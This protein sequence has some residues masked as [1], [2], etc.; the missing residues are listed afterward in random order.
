MADYHLWD[1]FIPEYSPNVNDFEIIF[2]P[3]G[4]AEGSITFSSEIGNLF[5]AQPLSTASG[6]IDFSSSPIITVNP[7]PI[8]AEGGISI[9]SDMGFLTETPP[10]ILGQAEGNITFSSEIPNLRKLTPISADGNIAIEST[11][12]VLIPTTPVAANFGLK[13]KSSKIIV[14][15]EEFGKK[16]FSLENYISIQSQLGSLVKTQPLSLCVGEITIN[17]EMGQLLPTV[18]LGNASFSILFTS[19]IQKPVAEPAIPIGM[20]SRLREITVGWG[21]SKSIAHEITIANA[22]PHDVEH[23]IQIAYDTTQS[24]N[25]TSQLKWGENSA[26]QRS[27]AIKFDQPENIL[28]INTIPWGFPIIKN[29]ACDV[30]W[31]PQTTQKIQQNIAIHWNKISPKSRI[32]SIPFGE[33]TPVAV[34]YVIPWGDFTIEDHKSQA[35]TIPWLRHTSGQNYEW[36]ILS[37]KQLPIKDDPD[38]PPT[39]PTYPIMSDIHIVRLPERIE[40]N[41]SSVKV[42]SD[43]DSWAWQIN[44]VPL[45]QSDYDLL[46]P[47]AVGPREIEINI[48]GYQWI[49]IIEKINQSKRF[50]KTTF[51]ASGRSRSAYLS[52]PYSVAKDFSQ[53]QPRNLQ[54]LANEELTNTGWALTWNTIDFLVPGDIFSYQNKTP[55]S[56]ILNIIESVGSTV[57]THPNETQLVVSP[58]HPISSWLWPLSDASAVLPRGMIYEEGLA[59]SQTP[60]YNKIFCIGGKSGGILAGVKRAGTAGE[61]LA[62]Q[63]VHDLLMHIDGGREKAR[64]VLSHAGKKRTFNIETSLLPGLLSPKTLLEVEGENNTSWIGQVMSCAVSTDGLVTRQNIEVDRYG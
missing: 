42:S 25:K 11:F 57:Q 22:R 14:Q 47:D 30:P 27:L 13:I 55:M 37:N 35:W 64:N 41:A 48:N 38:A 9:N 18:P 39:N 17:S 2:Q 1:D 51:S 19:E 4:Q 61:I 10:T 12:D 7:V 44:L 29:I 60:A 59:W 28:I 62:P 20:P 8:S 58:R 46:S 63:F 33:G 50:A 31:Q 45:S 3:L 43:I 24:I 34:N 6:N 16:I 54:Q 52:A 49:G 53:S 23:S 26:L 56:S 36:E 40:I 32:I 21:N 15:I 5:P